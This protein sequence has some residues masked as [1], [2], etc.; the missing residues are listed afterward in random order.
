MSD[1]PAEDFAYPPGF[2]QPETVEDI[3]NHLQK[4]TFPD[5]FSCYTHSGPG[6]VA[7]IYNEIIVKQEYFQNGLSVTEASCVMDIGAN[8]GIFTMAVKQ[9]APNATIYAFEPIP[10]T[11]QTLEQNVRSLDCSD[12]HLYNVAI[13]SQDHVEKTFTYF[14]NMPGNS[15][16]T[17]AL[18]DEQK[19]VMDRIFG[20]EMSDFLSQSETCIVQFRTLSSVIREQ[21]IT[22]VDYLKIDVEGDEISVLEGI[23]E[24][25][26]PIFKQV[27]VETHNTQLQEQVCEILVQHGFE[28]YSDLGLS[29]PVGVSMVYAHR[30]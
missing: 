10:D 11:F 2:V 8:V 14:P 5:G 20:K 29:S 3:A 17:P 16:A 22:S 24:I 25:H 21:G 7:L 4:I 18:K 15:T 28:V 13:G 23:E 12:I 1:S 19:S 9:K 27:A 30:S 6:E 26:W